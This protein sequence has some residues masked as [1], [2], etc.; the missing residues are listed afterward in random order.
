MKTHLNV[1]FEY[2]LSDSTV[3]SSTQD[4]QPKGKHSKKAATQSRSGYMVGSQDEEEM[5][6]KIHSIFVYKAIYRNP[7]NKCLK[8]EWD[9]V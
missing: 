5:C 7:N 8:G 6:L 9:N 2:L 3:C 1:I 4:D